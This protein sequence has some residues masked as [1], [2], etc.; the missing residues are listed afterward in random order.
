MVVVFLEQYPPGQDG[1]VVCLGS[2]R[3]D[4]CFFSAG[5]ERSFFST[6]GRGGF[7]VAS[8]SSAGMERVLSC[9]F[10]AGAGQPD[11]M[12]G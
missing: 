1:T 10:T 7:L 6:W 4:G 2:F 12:M 3:R 11:G 8:L 5:A 9:F